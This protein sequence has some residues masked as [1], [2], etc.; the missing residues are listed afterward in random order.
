MIFASDFDEDRTHS[1]L[2]ANDVMAL[3]SAIRKYKPYADAPARYPKLD[4]S[5]RNQMDG[6]AVA[7]VDGSKPY[8]ATTAQALS[9]VAWKLED[10]GSELVAKEG[11][12]SATYFSIE[13]NRQDLLADILTVL[14]S[15]PMPQGPT[16]FALVQ[17]GGCGSYGPAWCTVCRINRPCGC[18]TFYA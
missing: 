5:I 12:D 3:L 2:T 15:V 4:Q 10:L 16:Q 6:A 1:P 11:G 17:R 18:V 13:Q 14:Y 7:P 9:I 8:N